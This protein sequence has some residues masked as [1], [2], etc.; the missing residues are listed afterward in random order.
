MLDLVGRM[1]QSRRLVQNEDGWTMV[2]IRQAYIVRIRMV[3]LEFETLPW[4]FR[5]RV[6]GSLRGLI[7]TQKARGCGG[8]WLLRTVTGGYTGAHGPTRSARVVVTVVRYIQYTCLITKPRRGT[9]V[10]D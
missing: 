9:V 5:R 10:M 2:R 8:G 6:R 1:M 4:C 7:I 3:A